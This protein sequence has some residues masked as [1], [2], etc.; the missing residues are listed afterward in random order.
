MNEE[1]KVEPDEE[2]Q[3]EEQDRE[4]TA[5]KEGETIQEE[6]VRYS[7]EQDGLNWSLAHPKGRV[8]DHGHLRHKKNTFRQRSGKFNAD[9]YDDVDHSVRMYCASILL[10]FPQLTP[11]V[12][13]TL[14][15]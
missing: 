6:R 4:G 10:Y 14:C 8:C 13:D 15:V 12:F 5:E 2:D 9:L 1:A 3:A 7:R 11:C